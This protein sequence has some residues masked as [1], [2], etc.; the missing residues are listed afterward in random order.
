MKGLA[1]SVALVLTSACGGSSGGGTP[2]TPEPTVPTIPSGVSALVASMFQQLPA[3]IQ[4]TLAEN[5]ANLPR[6]PQAAAAINAKIA[7]L[8]RPGLAADISAGRLFV[9]SSV[10]STDG[11]RIS[12]AAMFP[13]E[14]YRTEAVAALD[15][16]A[17]SLPHLERFMDTP[18][19]AT[20]LRLWY[21]FTVGNSGGNAVLDMEDR[22]SYESRTPAS[23]QPYDAILAHEIAHTYIGNEAMTQFLE[24]Y[25][26]NR[27][28]G[29]GPDLA[30]WTFT[31]GYTGPGD[32][33][34]SSALLLDVYGLIGHDAMSRAYKAAVPL[35]PPYGQP[36]PEPVIDAFVDEAPPPMKEQV[37]AKLARVVG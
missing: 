15:V 18:F 1:L 26:Y 32:A 21:G 7:L 31:R 6:N 20:T 25:A 24:L 29:A 14:R 2:T 35:R 3:Y 4:S 10:T 27:A 30:T 37:R 28:L 16:T 12:M 19:P 5:Q 23:R 17:R 8:Q 11:R 33:N 22:T 9:E 34:E 13:E 36:I